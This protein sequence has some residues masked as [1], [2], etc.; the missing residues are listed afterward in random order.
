MRYS[1]PDSDDGNGLFGTLDVCVNDELIN[2]QPVSSYYCYQYFDIGSGHP[3]DTPGIG[4]PILGLMK[5]ISFFQKNLLLA[6]YYV[7]KKI[8]TMILFMA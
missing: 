2:S 5:F 7:F 8:Q 3:N 4:E 1:V 6:I